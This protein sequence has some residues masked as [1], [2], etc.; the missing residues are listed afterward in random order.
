MARLSHFPKTPF[1]LFLIVLLSFPL[2]PVHSP[3]G[4]A[5]ELVT[6]TVVTLDEAEILDKLRGAWAG[7]MIGVGWGQTTEFDAVGRILEEDEVPIWDPRS[8]NLGFWQD[9]LYAEITFLKSM[10]EGGVNCTWEMLAWRFV[11]DMIGQELWHAN[12]E[13]LQNLRGGHMP[14]DSGHFLYNEHCDDIDWQI[15]AD[16]AGEVAPGQVN[17]AIEI[18]WRLGHVTNYGDGVYGG[19]FVAAMHAKAFTASSVEEIIEAGRQAVPLGS[20]YR[21][22]IEDVLAWR[23]GRSW[24]EV[25]QLLEEKWGQDDRCPEGVNSPFNIDAKFNGA[26]VL[27]GLL[28]GNGDFEESMRIA[29]R[30]GQDSECNPSTVG[31]ILGNWLGFSRIPVKFTQELRADLPFYRVR[32]P[33]KFDDVVNISLEL[34]RQ[35]LQMNGGWISGTTWHIP[36]QGPIRPPILEQWPVWGNK[37]PILEVS[38]EQ[39]A[40]GTVHFRASA[41]DEDGTIQAYQWY[42]G[43]LVYTDGADVW[44]TY[45]R[46]GSYEAVGWVT[47]NVGNTACYPVTVRVVLPMATSTPAITPT[48]TPSPT[49]TATSTLTSSPTPTFTPELSATP[50]P[51]PWTY[52][53]PVLLQGR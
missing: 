16:L 9:D 42:F 48:Y 21:Q 4:K 27:L 14:P 18:A 45:S 32:P 17:T 38:V 15:E 20:K 1:C 50:T 41:Y 35:T 13:A 6:P 49:P 46:D 22:V 30:C 34:A 26:Y 8:I 31:G 33:Y 47:D 43:D 51:S 52:M 25:W 23:Q 53:L 29:L 7:Q 36:D 40:D 37:L 2:L 28:Y 12:W 19:V 3:F 5:Q 39:Q 10:S 24:E 11:D 44:H